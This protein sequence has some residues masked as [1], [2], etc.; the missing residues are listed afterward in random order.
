M[1]LRYRIGTKIIYWIWSSL[2]DF[3]VDGRK[4]IPVSGGVIIAANHL[5]NFDPPLIGTGVWSKECYYF[6]K[7]GL[8]VG[9]KFNA[10]L[11]RTFNAYEVDTEKPSKGALR[12]TQELLKQGLAVILFPEGT[13]SKVGHFLK[14]NP[15]V[16]WL[17]LTT[18]VPIVPTL[19]K[20]TNTSLWS[21]FIRKNKAR[22]RFGSPISPEYISKLKPCKGSR[23]IIAQEVAKRIKLL[24][25][26]TSNT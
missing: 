6:T 7:R 23:N 18:K 9:N 24:D 16:G 10:W 19:V 15:G 5:S 8:F 2:F 26:S 11:I 13:R 20:G 17:A 12:Y 21:Q 1:K 22:V 14:F 25:E 3:K 4:N